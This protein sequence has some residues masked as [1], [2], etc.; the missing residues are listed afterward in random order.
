MTYNL[1]SEINIQQYNALLNRTENIRN[2]LDKNGLEFLLTYKMP[3]TQLIIKF[4]LTN[5][6][7]M[8]LEEQLINVLTHI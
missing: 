8:G 3:L 6:S 2:A 7:I 5:F 4:S 1:V